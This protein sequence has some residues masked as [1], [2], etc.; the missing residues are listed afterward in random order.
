MHSYLNKTI[1][2]CYMREYAKLLYMN[3]RRKVF[4]YRIFLIVDYRLFRNK[5]K[6]LFNFMAYRVNLFRYKKSVSLIYSQGFLSQSPLLLGELC[7]LYGSDKGSASL[8]VK[9]YPWP[10]HTYISI[11]SLIFGLNRF[12]VSK[13]LECGIGSNSENLKSNMTKSGKPG[14][15]LRVWR[16]FF[17]EAEIYGIDIDP[18]TLFQENR[19]KTFEVD[20][21]SARSINEF[22]A[23]IPNIEFDIVIDD[24]LHEFLA[25]KKLFSNL[26]SIVRNYGF[27]V[28]EDIIPTDLVK[29]REYFPSI[30][31]PF[32]IFFFNDR[33][34]KRSIDNVMIVIQK[35]NL[36]KVDW[37]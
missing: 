32:N 22:K 2:L 5:L 19:I 16:D 7:D 34:Q 8:E 35:S 27:Y 11:Y 24:G 13:V 9:P 28:I 26:Y 20:Q 21:T 15:S 37:D 25:G 31:L 30:N 12:A 6:T 14:A 4:I 29:Y 23:K 17:P 33:S 18:K 36:V 3:N 1:S 10:P